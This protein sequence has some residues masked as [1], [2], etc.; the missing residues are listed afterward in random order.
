MLRDAKSA[1]LQCLVSANKEYLA[2]AQHACFG[3]YTVELSCSRI[4]NDT[5]PPR[6][7]RAWGALGHAYLF[8]YFVEQCFRLMYYICAASYIVPSKPYQKTGWCDCFCSLSVHN[9]GLWLR[10]MILWDRAFG[11]IM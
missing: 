4:S 7:L 5:L 3:L 9:F 6:L 11:Q 1:T 10:N 8:M 2:R